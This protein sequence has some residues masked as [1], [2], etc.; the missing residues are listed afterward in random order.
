MYM[1]P[2]QQYIRDLLDEYGALLKRQLLKMIN[3]KFRTQK[4]SIDGYI[5]QMCRYA[6]YEVV[7]I[8][9]D[10]AV[11]QKGT[12]PDYDIIRSFDVLLAFMPKAQYHRKSRDFISIVFIIETDECDKEVFVIPVK[13]GHEKAVSSF[14]NDKFDNEKN[15]VVI[16]LLEDKEQIKRLQTNSNHKFAVIEKSGVKFIKHNI[17]NN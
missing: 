17:H 8:G 9:A 7:A 12:E 13:A 15:E 5:L 10:D 6:D 4:S 3:F 14:T 11:C 16:F 1:N 2:Y